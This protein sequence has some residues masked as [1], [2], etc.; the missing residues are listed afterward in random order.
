[1]QRDNAAKIAC[2]ISIFVLI[3]AALIVVNQLK[4]KIENLPPLEDEL[5]FNGEI[6][7][8][9]AKYQVDIGFRPP[10]S[11]NI[12]LL[13][14]YMVNKVKSFGWKVS[15]QNS[16]KD[17][18]L[19]SNILA[20]PEN[21]STFYPKIIFAAHYD[22]RN[23]TEKDDPKEYPDQPCMGANDGASGVAVLLEFA[24]IL[25]NY[26]SSADIGL[27][28]IDAEDQGS[29][30]GIHGINEWDWCEGA[31]SYANNLSTQQIEQIEA[32]I[33]LDMI[34]DSDLQI[35]REGYSET[36]SR[37]LNNKIWSVA[38]NLDYD[39]YFINSVKYTMTDDHKAFIDKG[40]PAI[41][42]IDFDYESIEGENF[43]HTVNDTLDK[44]SANSLKV[45]G[46]V[47]ESFILHYYQ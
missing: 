47:C 46:Q 24:R 2:V 14:K 19:I 38:N 13:R 35:Y 27:L 39:N 25:Q 23:V 33:L 45:V 17:G 31:E 6:A 4:P 8:N 36:H 16:T 11:E 40:I 30:R 22:T 3:F 20:T 34:G 21:S 5:L 41:D 7:Y 28:F 44:I 43:H 10:D 1:M 12:E 18:I 42:L 15:Y 37:D 29:S 26:T 32:F 9:F